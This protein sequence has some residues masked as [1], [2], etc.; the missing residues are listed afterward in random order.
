MRIKRDTKQLIEQFASQPGVE[1]E[2][3][4]CKSKEIIESSHGRQKL[5]K[6]LSSMANQKGGTLTSSPA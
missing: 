6:V 4:D 5:V 3:F 2:E 1:S